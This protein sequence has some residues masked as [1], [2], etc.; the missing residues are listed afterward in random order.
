MKDINKYWL[1][2][3]KQHRDLKWMSYDDWDPELQDH[4]DVAIKSTK[5]L[6]DLLTKKVE[7]K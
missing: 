3:N 5:A 2:V 4:I 7:N 1:Q 6:L